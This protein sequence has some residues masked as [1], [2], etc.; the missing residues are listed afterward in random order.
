MKSQKP[1]HNRILS[2]RVSSRGLA[3]IAGLAIATF[4]SGT[5]VASAAVPHRGKQAVATKK[6]AEPETPLAAL[7]KVIEKLDRHG[8]VNVTA[9][10]IKLAGATG[11]SEGRPIEFQA[12][13]QDYFAYTEGSRPDFKIP[14]SE[15][16]ASMQILDV[17]LP[18]DSDTKL[19]VDVAHLNADHVL[20]TQGA[21]HVPVGFTTNVGM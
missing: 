21:H 2:P 10:T 11:I 8:S 12:N 5:P 13:G 18:S 15:T 17:Q 20:V 4:G 1:H 6:G 7:T 3:L 19:P 9:K 14:A 16:A